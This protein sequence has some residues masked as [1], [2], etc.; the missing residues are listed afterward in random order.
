MEHREAHHLELG[1]K[2]SE[3]IP[4]MGRFRGDRRNRPYPVS[5]P[6]ET[7]QNL[8]GGNPTAARVGRERTDEEEIERHR[9]RCGHVTESSIASVRTGRSFPRGVRTGSARRTRMP[10]PCLHWSTMK[11]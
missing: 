6:R 11:G 5:T 10:P 4:G 3:A 2:R 1:M 9:H 7:N 8:P